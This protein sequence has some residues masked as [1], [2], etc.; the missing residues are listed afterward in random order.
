MR[1]PAFWNSRNW[2]MRALM[3]I[4]SF[5]DSASILYRAFQPVTTLPIPVI[6]V[7]NLTLGG[8]GKT[9]VALH[10]GQRMK[11]RGINTY[12]LS[13]GYGG[14][15]AHPTLID[16][17]K[18]SAAQAGDEPLLLARLLPTVVA[19]D[20]VAGALF[21]LQQGAQAIIMDDGFQNPR[22][23]KTLSL[24]VINGKTGFGNGRVFPAGP[25]REK[26]QMGL[27]RAHAAIIINPTNAL[28][29]L[30]PEMI[31]MT[32]RTQAENVPV[33]KG[34]KVIAFAGIAY[35]EG[36]FDMLRGLGA[37][38]VETMS[39]P[40]H[41]PYQRADLKRLGDKARALQA[42]LVTTAKDAV[43]LPAFFREKVSVIDLSLVFD[44]EDIL[45][46]LLDYAMDK[47]AK[48]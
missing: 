4:A 29:K 10:I 31:V 12:F 38:P 30:L 35:P 48:P 18:H 2:A 42:P 39:F 27:R 7:G 44:R 24:V 20:R 34:Q 5:Y 25:M 32:A 28:P 40:D 17:Q 13:R 46:A 21:A 37:Q 6:C 8:A 23:A 45:D 36:F 16:P 14:T 1:A 19:K 41:Y 47:H 3:P 9:P 26:P 11:A 33:I 43:R 15:L 22:L